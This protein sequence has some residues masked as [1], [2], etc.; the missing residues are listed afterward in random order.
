MRKQL[1]VLALLLATFAFACGTLK[2]AGRTANDAASILCELFAAENQQAVG[3][4]PGDWCKLHDN[5]EP[6][7]DQALAAKQAAGAAAL[8]SP[9]ADDASSVT[10]ADEAQGTGP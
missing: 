9:N 6:F 10:P 2:D 1:S 4:S 8:G 7:I 5:L 3:M